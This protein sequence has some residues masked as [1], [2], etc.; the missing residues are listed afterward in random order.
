MYSKCKRHLIY[1]NDF[2]IYI[3]PRELYNY[4]ENYLGLGVLKN[5]HE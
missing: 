4:S 5:H 3:K 2:Y 1:V